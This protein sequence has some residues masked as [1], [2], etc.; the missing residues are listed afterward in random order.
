MVCVL[1]PLLLKRNIGVLFGVLRGP[2]NDAPFFCLLWFCI[3]VM[4]SCFLLLSFE[5]LFLTYYP[6]SLN[7]ADRVQYLHEFP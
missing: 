4:S 7:L 2:R 1:L 6:F 3:V 5:A